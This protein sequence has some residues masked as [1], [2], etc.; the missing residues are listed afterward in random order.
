MT[1]ETLIKKYSKALFEVTYEKGTAG[2]SA[3]QLL[4]VSKAFSEDVVLFFKNPFNQ[5][6]NK[7]SVAK[8]AIEGKVSVEVFNFICLLVEKNRVGLIS[9][10]AKDFSTLVQSSAGITK[11]KLFAATNVSAEFIKQV[12]EQASKTLGKK[13]ELTFEKDQALIAGYKVQVGGW[14]MDD[15][16]EAHLRILKEELIKKGL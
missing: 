12:E 16:A 6:E 5:M 3:Q 7:L 9:E 11:G 15:S 10:M 1:N 14:T 8:S 13:V 2:E 4:E